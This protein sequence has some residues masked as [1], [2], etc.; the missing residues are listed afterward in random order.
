V[1]DID[2]VIQSL[3]QSYPTIAVQQLQVLH[4]GADDDGL[5]FF[6]HPSTTIE[7][8]LESSN[9]SCPFIFESDADSSVEHPDSVAAAVALVARG[10][11]LISQAT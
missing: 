3:Q 10:L 5:W 1:R 11:G 6:T 7:V 4:P 2:L 8:Q 9:G